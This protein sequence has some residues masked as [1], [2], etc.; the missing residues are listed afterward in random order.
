[1]NQQPQMGL[2]AA[3]AAASD[4][5]PKT[6]I[7]QRDDLMKDESNIAP[8]L[9]TS[10]EAVVA[11]NA[12][13]RQMA[14]PGQN[15][16]TVCCTEV[17]EEAW[18]DYEDQFVG[19]MDPPMPMDAAYEEDKYKPRVAVV[20]VFNTFE[21]AD[22]HAAKCTA[23]AE[24]HG[25]PW[26]FDAL[27]M[28]N[29]EPMPPDISVYDDVKCHKDQHDLSR[30]YTQALLNKRNEDRRIHQRDIKN[31]HALNRAR[32]KRMEY[33]RNRIERKK[34]SLSRVTQGGRQH[35]P[36]QDGGG[37]GGDSTMMADN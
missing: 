27:P 4:S 17:S 26:E 1:M 19:A 6:M 22:A 23:F 36:L 14:V 33:Q 9:N 31:A 28:Y 18:Q 24:Q 34:Q 32:T 5:D 20:G 25:A 15:Y 35:H 21:E 16:M 7:G 30:Q 2:G 29:N 8:K 13:F 3:S 37:D 11:A 12:L 10:V